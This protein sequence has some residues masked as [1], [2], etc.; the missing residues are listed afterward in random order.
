VHS[1]AANHPGTFVRLLNALVALAFASLA[2]AAYWPMMKLVDLHRADLGIKGEWIGGHAK[3]IT[4]ITPNGA[5]DLAGLRVGDVLEFDP[6]VEND[7]ILAG[8]RHMPEGFAA[9]MPVQRADGA[10]S[11]VLFK[12]DRVPF[13]PASNDVMATAAQLITASVVILLGVVLIWLR[14][15][16]MTWSLFMAYFAAFPYFPWT[17][18]LLAFE[19]GRTLE[20]WSIVASLFQCCLVML[21][22]FAL[23]FPR[24]YLHHWPVWK[25]V[26]GAAL[27][28]AVIVLGASQLRVVPF[29]LDTTSFETGRIALVPGMFVPI[30]M[31]AVLPLMW[32]YRGAD[33]PTRAR[34]RWVLL[35]MAAPM[36][37]ICLAIVLGIVPYL[38]SGTVSGR[39]LTVPGWVIAIG[40][41]I[42]F[43]I[44][45]GIA[46]LRERVEDIQFA[47]S[48]TLVYGA[49]STLVLVILAAVHWLLGKMIEQTHL[50]IGLEGLAAVGLGLV[51]HR[52]TEAT[53]HFVDRVLFRKR[54]AAEAHLRRIMAALPFAAGLRVIGDALVT[55]PAR[56]LDLASAAVFYR[57]TDAGPL[58]RQS[59]VGWTDDHVASLDPDCLLVRCLQAGHEPLRIGDHE[60][61]PPD[62]PQGAALPVLA[63]PVASQS[64]LRA[65]VLYGAHHNSTLPDRDEVA[66]LHQLAMAA[67]KSHQ[68]VRIAAL[69]RDGH[70]KQERIGRL[71]ASLADL[72]A[73]V[74][75]RG[76]ADASVRSGR[77]PS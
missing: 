69:A 50:A 71:E 7:W 1:T 55:E 34:L 19:T 44:A 63:V 24:N 40:A 59:S 77:L 43:P 36:I 26:V 27:C 42:L 53:N 41:G 56:E 49:V 75:A 68:Q 20:F 62:T 67:E 37:A 5:A 12:P 16:F 74:H 38:A 25:Q 30:L 60:L 31:L 39:L 22:P 54:H 32:S 23:C 61:L 45:L 46:V 33:G 9:R 73:L 8:Y 72:R 10:L 13:L 35:G 70:E 15:G 14:P 48:R 29:E 2:L 21:V 76:T 65:V 17:A 51:L 57:P 58:Q 64:A 4:K 18:Y 6:R 3:R 11:L 47:V 28:V 52:V 66:L